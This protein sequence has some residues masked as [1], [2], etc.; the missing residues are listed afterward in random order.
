MLLSGLPESDVFPYTEWVIM[1][2]AGHHSET[3]VCVR[4][5]RKLYIIHTV[6]WNSRDK[7]SYH[8]HYL[9]WVVYC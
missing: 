8:L 1:K 6:T 3:L 4:H 7:S 9:H 2:V 5:G